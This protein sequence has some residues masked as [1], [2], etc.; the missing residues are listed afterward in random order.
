MPASATVTIPSTGVIRN[1]VAPSFDF[2]HVSRVLLNRL[3]SSVRHLEEPVGF[4]NG[5]RVVI[6]VYWPARWHQ[7]PPISV[8]THLSYLELFHHGQSPAESGNRGKSD[9]TW[10]LGPRDRLLLRGST[11][12]HQWW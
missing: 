3:R 4:P 6:N 7:L 2:A 11:L 5:G 1:P 12:Q 9:A 10:A 8:T